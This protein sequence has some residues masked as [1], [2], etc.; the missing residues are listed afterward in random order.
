VFSREFSGIKT[1]LA[2]ELNWKLETAN[3]CK[4]AAAAAATGGQMS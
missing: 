4:A 1:Q 2:V 3:G